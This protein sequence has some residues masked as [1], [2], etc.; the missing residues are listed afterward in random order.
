MN[1]DVSS[2][3]YGSAVGSETAVEKQSCQAVLNY[4][5]YVG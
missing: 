4:A 2:C 1:A 3:Y 5:C